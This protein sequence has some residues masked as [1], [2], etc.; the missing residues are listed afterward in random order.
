MDNHVLVS[1]STTGKFYDT[2]NFI[3]DYNLDLKTVCFYMDWDEANKS[4]KYG[5]AT[6]PKDL[7][8]N[9]KSFE[10]AFQSPITI[11]NKQNRTSGLQN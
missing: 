10:D 4:W 9:I 3:F 11:K 8:K 2:T 7:K 6:E 1:R 5:V